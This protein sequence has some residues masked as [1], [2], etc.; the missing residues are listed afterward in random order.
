MVLK[1]GVI[2]CG[3]IGQRRSKI[4]NSSKNS[5]VLAV[6]DVDLEKAK[7]L[8]NELNCDYYDNWE[9]ITQNDEIDAVLVSTTGNYLAK[10]SYQVALKG[11]HIFC[12]KPLG[13]NVD[14][15]KRVVEEAKKRNLVFK[16]GFT[17]RFHPG[18]KKIKSIIDQNLI[19]KIIFVNCKY[20]ITGRPGY[21]KE[22]RANPELSGGGELIDQGIHVLDL[23]RWFMGDFTEVSGSI[24]TLYWD[25]SVEDNAFAIL[26]TVDNQMASLHVSWTRWDNLFSLEVF[27]EQGYIIMNG[28][29]GVYGKETITVGKKA[30][31]DKWP[32]EET[33]TVF[34]NPEE[35]WNEEW[36]E[37]VSSINNNSEPIGSGKDGLEA[38]KLVFRIYDFCKNK[39]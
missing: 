25:T 36:Q 35:S 29:G 30:P 24:G 19:G 39:N 12:E 28:L 4:I 10:I 9:K 23:L 8:G 21:E 26:K 15:V 38:L 14:E 13:T 34:A 1:I 2:G 18:I 16:S 20:G 22:W 37:F 32:P 5:K 6:A 27:C 11:K 3:V 7:S 31:P 33:V 17:L